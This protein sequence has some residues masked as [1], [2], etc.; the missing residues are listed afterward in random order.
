MADSLVIEAVRVFLQQMQYIGFNDCLSVVLV[1]N[2][3]QNELS[4]VFRMTF[5][6]VYSVLSLLQNGSNLFP[7]S[8]Q[9][10]HPKALR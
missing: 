6:L 9:D 2:F 1:L 7:H 10:L 4:P 3:L 8:V 5:V